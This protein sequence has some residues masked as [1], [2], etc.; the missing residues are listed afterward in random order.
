MPLSGPAPPPP[1]ER[2]GYYHAVS[3]SEA[4]TGIGTAYGTATAPSAPTL[5]VDAVAVPK[6]IAVDKTVV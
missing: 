1:H 6:A 3:Q 5:V 2:R 4:E